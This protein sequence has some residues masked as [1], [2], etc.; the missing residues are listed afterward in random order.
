MQVSFI[1]Q[2]KR[3]MVSVVILAVVSVAV[4]LVL[5]LIF[6]MIRN[7]SFKKE[8]RILKEIED[9]F[10]E[11]EE[12]FEKERKI[13]EGLGKLYSKAEEHMREEHRVVESAAERDAPKK[14]IAT[15]GAAE[16][17]KKEPKHKKAAAPK[18]KGNSKRYPR[19]GADAT[20]EVGRF[21]SMVDE[22]LGKLPEEEIRKF[23]SSKDYELYKKIMER[24]AKDA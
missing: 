18:G 6:L 11:E 19:D 13:K 20:N 3:K 8:D 14:M 4:V 24:H 7:R 9:L 5:I 22:L 21:F 16:S 2:K 17:A 23:S 15:E 12:L 1:Y 10:K